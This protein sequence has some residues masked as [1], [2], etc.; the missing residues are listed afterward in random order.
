MHPKVPPGTFSLNYEQLAPK[1]DAERRHFRTNKDNAIVVPEP[2]AKELACSD[3]FWIW[4]MIEAAWPQ[5]RE[6]INHNLYPRDSPD[7]R[8]RMMRNQDHEHSTLFRYLNWKNGHNSH[9]K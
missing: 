3:V 5:W 4:R 2:T 9:V 6:H 7:D 1:V 8:V